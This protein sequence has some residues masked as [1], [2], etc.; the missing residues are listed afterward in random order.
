MTF[1][2]NAHS[3]ESRESQW[4]HY[5]QVREHTGDIIAASRESARELGGTLSQSLSKVG[6]AFRSGMDV[7]SADIREVEA[8]VAELTHLM[9]WRTSVLISQQFVANVLI[10]NV[11]ELLRIPDAQKERQYHVT[12]GLEFFRNAGKNPKRY[13]DALEHLRAAEKHDRTDYVVLY[14]IGLIY[15]HDPASLDLPAAEDYFRRAADYAG[16][17]TEPGM[18]HG[19][20]LLRERVDIPFPTAGDPEFARTFAAKAYFEAAVS[21]YLQGKLRD[22]TSLAAETL[23]LEP[24]LLE[25]GVVRIK[26]LLELG[27]PGAAAELLEW[28]VRQDSRYYVRAA[29]E[30]AEVPEITGL[31]ARLHQEAESIAQARVILGEAV[32][33]TALDF[34]SFVH[35]QGGA[36]SEAELSD[37]RELART[38]RE[39]AERA[40]YADR[41]AAART[42][43]E[44]YTRVG[45]VIN[46]VQ[47]DQ[48][49]RLEAERSSL[50]RHLE[51]KSQELAQQIDS[52][53]KRM[54]HD[55]RHR[56]EQRKS[57]VESGLQARK[58]ISGYG[59]A[60]SCLS[61]LILVGILVGVVFKIF[62]DLQGDLEDMGGLAIWSGFGGV[63][64]L[65]A[66]L[67]TRLHNTI[68]RRTIRGLK[69]RIRTAQLN[70]EQEV[71]KYRK[72]QEG[73]FNTETSD[74]RNRLRQLD[75]DLE[76]LAKRHRE[77][78]EAIPVPTTP[79]ARLPPIG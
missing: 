11:A 59:C 1:V 34:I 19:P 73:E 27:E 63:C 16:D 79:P 62:E 55:A 22:A 70:A 42:A 32:L 61:Y 2:Y 57:D 41:L 56:L 38:A 50:R 21:C 46:H 9:D 68:D 72:E 7:L 31:L 8:K 36:A 54:R 15:L 67:L 69:A 66:F 44:V 53:V 13:A 58:L 39:L 30:L 10:G 18:A 76:M 51:K 20:N 12:R 77:V 35:A 65:V 4:H 37:A 26:A 25:A 74:V 75:L 52:A 43:G 40:E 33:A 17:E 29:A 47:Q 45:A 23:K 71:E 60:M 6:L 3:D 28:V 78:L 49:Q 64:L 48:I 24:A 14:H 5:L